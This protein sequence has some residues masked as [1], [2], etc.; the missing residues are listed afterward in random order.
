MSLYKRAD[1]H[2]LNLKKNEIN[3][4]STVNRIAGDFVDF[5]YL[6][7]LDDELPFMQPDIP[8]MSIGYA[9]QKCTSPILQGK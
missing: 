8:P 9:K 7:H 1:S 2:S 3:L 5:V 6:F 4:H